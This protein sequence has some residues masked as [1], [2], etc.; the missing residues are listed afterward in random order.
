[1]QLIKIHFSAAST[2]YWYALS[3]ALLIHA[4]SAI[5]QIIIIIIII[6]IVY[7][8]TLS[9]GHLHDQHGARSGLSL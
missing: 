2:S 9:V 3:S 1:M 5:K 8:Y 6:I 4:C 7:S